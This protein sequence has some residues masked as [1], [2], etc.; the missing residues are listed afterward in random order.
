MCVLVGTVFEVSDVAHEALVFCELN[1][2]SVNTKKKFKIIIFND[3]FPI[4]VYIEING[5]KSYIIPKI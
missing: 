1:W 2:K 5:G 3:S 4:K